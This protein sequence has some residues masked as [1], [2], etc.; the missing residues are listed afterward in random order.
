M[1]SVAGRAGV[2]AAG[3]WGMVE[4]RMFFAGARGADPRLLE[5]ARFAEEFEFVDAGELGEPLEQQFSLGEG[6][7]QPIY[8]LR[9]PGQPLLVAFDQRRQRSGPTGSVVSLRTFVAVRGSS[10]QSAPPMRAAARRGKALESLE[11]SRSGAQRLTVENDPVFEESVS[12]YTREP[13][14]AQ[15][16]LTAPV[17][18]VL[19]RLLLAADQAALNAN[20]TGGTFATTV[21]PSLVVGQ[22]NLL[23]CLEPRN[24]LPVSALGS[25]LADML[26]LHVAL[27]SAGRQLSENRLED[28]LLD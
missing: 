19:R 5:W 14:S 4:W 17:R 8:A 1:T 10:D 21:A 6:Q 9:R 26:S 7:L 11:A 20:G 2:P 25:L 16:V 12:V 15:A 13:R 27:D 23:L 24:A 3:F 22:R 18:E 28:A